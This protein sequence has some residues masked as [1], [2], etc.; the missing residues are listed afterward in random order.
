MNDTT[1]PPCTHHPSSHWLTGVF[2][3]TGWLCVIFVQFSA[4]LTSELAA[5]R[6][7]LLASS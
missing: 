6:T 5:G 2:G 3:F 1:I 7:C 4:W